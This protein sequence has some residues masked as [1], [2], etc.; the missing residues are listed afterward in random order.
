MNSNTKWRFLGTHVIFIG[1]LDSQDISL[2]YSN[3]PPKSIPREHFS[4]PSGM[5]FM[6]FHGT[7]PEPG[8][9][10]QVNSNKNE[11]FLEPMRCDLLHPG[12]R[13]FTEWREKIGRDEKNPHRVFLILSDSF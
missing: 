1:K 9:K 4:H 8:W 13:P 5:D 10:C 2:S 12:G 7:S 3:K 6:E 11:G